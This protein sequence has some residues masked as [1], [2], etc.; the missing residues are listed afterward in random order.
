M[1][2]HTRIEPETTLFD[3]LLRAGMA[4][5][6]DRHVVL[7]RHSVHRVHQVEKIGF[8]IDILFTMGGKQNILA[9]L[10][11][12][13]FEDVARLDLFQVI[14]QYLRH[15]RADDIGT[16]SR[17]SGGI[18][19]PACMFGITH[20]DI[21]RHIHDTAVCLFRKTFVEAAV[22]GFH[23]EDRDMQALRSDHRKAGVRIAKHQDRIRLH[24]DH[25]LV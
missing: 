24:L 11:P 9:F 15:R 10:Q 5:I 13:T 12:Q 22:T 8:R 20:V 14:V 16:L 2:D 6:K 17:R 21:G 18:Q 4:G 25:Q 23:M 7:L 1:L 3:E 19:I